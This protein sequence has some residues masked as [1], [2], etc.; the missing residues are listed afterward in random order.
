M[1]K[2]A[3]AII[4]CS[5]IAGLSGCYKADFEKEKTRATNLEAELAKAKSDLASASQQVTAA[6]QAMGV[7]RALQNGEFEVQTIVNG[8]LIGKDKVILSGANS[9]VK[10]GERLRQTGRL[11]FNRGQL[12]DQTFTINRESNQ[13]KYVEG[14]IRGGKADGEWIWYDRAGKPMR[15]ETWAAG[16]IQSVERVATDRAGK[17]TFTK[18]AKKDQDSWIDSTAAVFA[19]IPE[20]SREK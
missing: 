7:V 11:T 8:T 9:L 6:Q 15:R 2:F 10:H 16:K 13:Q 19:A 17:P 20:L 5:L 14:T 12:A 3:A 18:L 4:A 1:K